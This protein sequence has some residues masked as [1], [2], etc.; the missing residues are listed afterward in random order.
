MAQARSWIASE[1]QRAAGFLA[2]VNDGG[3]RK[4]VRELL[5]VG[6]VGN[7]RLA[8]GRVFYI[9][10]AGAEQA[11]LYQ[12]A[13][14]K[15]QVVFDPADLDARAKVAW[16]HPSPSGRL[17]AVG[18]TR[19]G[20]VSSEAYIKRIDTGQQQV[21]DLSCLEECSLAWL[22]DDSGF[23][24]TRQPN[25]AVVNR[26]VVF[27][28]LGK[29]VKKDRLVFSG[30]RAKVYW[31]S[32]DLSPDN[33]HLTVVVET[34]FTNTE[35]FLI[36]RTSGKTTV[37]A[38]GLDATTNNLRF[39][40]GRL[41]ALTTYAAPRGR[42]VTLDTDGS[43]P[44]R[45]N[46]VVREQSGALRR[47]EPLP[48][49]VLC[50]VD[51]RVVSRLQLFD[52]NGNRRGEVRPPTLGSIKRLSVNASASRAVVAFQSFTRPDSLLAIDLSPNR[53]SPKEALP[54]V[55]LTAAVHLRPEDY[56]V[57]QVSY[58]SFDGTWVPM[59][60]LSRK[61]TRLGDGPRPMLLHGYGAYGASQRPHFLPHAMAWIERGGVWGVAN[62]RGGGELGETWH[63]AGM[64][65]KKFQ[66]FKDFEYAMRYLISRRITS[67]DRLA[68]EGI[69]AG[70]LLMG[71][72][73]TSAPYLFACAI[74]SAGFFDLVRL[75]RYSNGKAHGTEFGDADSRDDLGYVLGYS[76]YHQ[77]IGGVR[78]P[79]FFADAME[80]DPRAPWMHTAK[81]VAALQ[82]ATSSGKPI[83]FRLRKQAGHGV[84]LTNDE[85]AEALVDALKFV[86]SQ[87]GDPG[88][89]RRSRSRAG[90]QQGSQQRLACVFGSPPG[91]PRSLD[92]IWSKSVFDR[93]VSVP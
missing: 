10:K 35:V 4:R 16:Y 90:G 84:G 40:G 20:K 60:L 92:E 25:P 68:I 85:K 61:T 15:E 45:W 88:E 54:L 39:S 93:L 52:D 7:P 14:G 29:S 26:N 76:P 49:G 23:Y 8:G 74:A 63:R 75:T 30:D 77:V 50:V 24:Y 37:L 87:I 21:L 31:P 46:T 43:D 89:A 66:S 44:A 91:V 1:D 71:G 11:R 17:V 22:S 2:K 58:P 34:S 51:D 53:P 59:F 32:V 82:A 81:F 33:R 41:L 73:M 56:V 13:G 80:N 18:V 48:D 3:L 38:R 9:K 6:F 28:R 42:V 64:K 69:S 36:E 55:S 27:H 72:M 47:F 70:G 78:Y 79:A 12:L 67:V 83:L 62:I 57:R 5:E 65:N 86:M 19:S